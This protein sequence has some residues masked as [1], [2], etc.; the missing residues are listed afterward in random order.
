MSLLSSLLSEH[1]SN[2]HTLI[3]ELLALYDDHQKLDHIL[4]FFQTTF[5]QT[6]LANEPIVTVWSYLIQEKLWSARYPSLTTFQTAVHFNDIIKP[7][8]DE[9]QGFLSRTIGPFGTIY[10]NWEALPEAVIPDHIRPSL[11]SQY[12]ARELAKLSQIC[13]SDKAIELIEA[14]IQARLSTPSH[15]RCYYPYVQ[16]IDV[17]KAYETL[18]SPRKIS[19]LNFIVLIT[20]KLLLCTEPKATLSETSRDCG[21]GC[22]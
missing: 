5:D 3:C 16:S 14:Q 2:L 22:V 20:S 1:D 15:G 4:H 8:L 10:R 6:Q 12:L 7:V 19:A 13:S 17:L 21:F 18:N 9:S 11:I